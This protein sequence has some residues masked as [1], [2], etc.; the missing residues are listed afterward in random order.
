MH[1]VLVYVHVKPAFVEAIKTASTKNAANSIKES[2][3]AR[4]D[5]IQ[6]QS[7]SNRF[8][9]HEAYRDADAPKKHKE[10]QHY[11]EWRETVAPMMAEPRVGIA[12]SEI[13]PESHEW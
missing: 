1:I 5:L 4:F 9:L 12:Y 7:D 13:Y 10:T 2:G 3:V 11:R 6:D 8:V